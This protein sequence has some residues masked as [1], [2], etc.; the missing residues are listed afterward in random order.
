[1]Y[2]RHC[3][4]GPRAQAWAYLCTETDLFLCFSVRFFASLCGYPRGYV[5]SVEVSVEVSGGL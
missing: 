2:D 3:L 5:G 1:M 4:P